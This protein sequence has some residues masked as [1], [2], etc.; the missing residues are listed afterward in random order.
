MLVVHY[1]RIT[2]P[3]NAE[4]RHYASLFK[5]DRSY[6]ITEDTTAIVI[7]FTDYFDVWTDDGNLNSYNTTETEY[8]IAKDSETVD[9]KNGK[10]QF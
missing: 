2:V 10:N 8:T 1:N 4:G 5:D 7:E 9:F 6:K 3:Q